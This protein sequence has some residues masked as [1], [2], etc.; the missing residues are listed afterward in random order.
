MYNYKKLVMIFN[1]LI[2]FISIIS[3]LAIIFVSFVDIIKK[4]LIRKISIY[5]SQFIY[6]L[7]LIYLLIFDK[8]SG[9]FQFVYNIPL[10][11]SLNISYVIGID[12]ISIFLIILTTFLISICI[13]VSWESI[14]VNFKYFVILLFLT[15]F[16]LINAFSMLNLFFFLYFLRVL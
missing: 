1:L 5:F 6:I 10:F 13:L 4:N 14:E 12:G 3:L 9:V 8:T 2:V 7:S 15:E 16:L 11:E